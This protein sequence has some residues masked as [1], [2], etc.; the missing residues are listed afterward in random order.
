MKNYVGGW[1][2]CYF[3]VVAHNFFITYTWEWNKEGDGG[4]GVEL[5]IWNWKCNLKELIEERRDFFM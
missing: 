1:M 2:L 4:W 5:D 3:V